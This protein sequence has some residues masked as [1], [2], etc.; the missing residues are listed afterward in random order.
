MLG[1]M[2][3]GCSSWRRFEQGEEANRG[4]VMNSENSDY[5]KRGR[6]ETQAAVEGRLETEASSA[7]LPIDG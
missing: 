7:V 3:S 4:S 1:V 6:I 5:I 2:R